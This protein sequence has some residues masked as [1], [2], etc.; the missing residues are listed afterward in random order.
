MI[1]KQIVTGFLKILIVGGLCFAVLQS[2]AQQQ[3]SLAG[4]WTVKLDSQ[5]VGLQQK[6]YSQ[7]FEETIQLP[8]T[9][10]D[11]GMGKQTNLTADKLTR[12]VVLE[13]TRKHSYIG[14]AWYSKEVQIPQNWKDK[15]ITLF[16]GRVIWN[17]RIWIDG[18]EAGSDESLSVPQRFNL[19]TLL[20]PGKHRVTIRI[21]NTKQYDI[22]HR[23]MAHAYT[24]GTQIIWNG[25]IGKISLIARNKVQINTIQT[26]PDVKNASVTVSTSFENYLNHSVSKVFRLRIFEKNK[27]LVYDKKVALNISPGENKK[28]LKISLGKKALLWDEFNPDLYKVSAEIRD[29]YGI[30]DAQTTTFGMREI[31]HEQNVLRVN[32]RQ[33]YLRGTLECDIFPLTGHPPMDKNGWLK[34]FNT[35]KEYGL[36]HIRF[37]SWCPPEPAFEVADS[38][39]FYLQ[40]ELPLWSKESGNEAK[41]NKFIADEA[42]RI[43]KEYGNHPSFCLWSLGNELEGDF[44]WLTKLLLELKAR[45]TR[46]LYTTTT[47]SFQKDHGVWPEPNDEFFITQYTKKGWVRGQGI[48]NTYSPN[49]S[50][51]Y[52]KALA[53]MPVPMITHEM[54]QYSVYPNLD[55][56]KKYTGVLDPL[57]FKAIRNDLQKKNMLELA[58]DFTLASGKFSANLYKEEIE[59]NLKTKGMSGFQL[60]DLHDFPG[61]GTA[62]V[63]ILDA[64][65]DSKGLIAPREHRMYCAPVVPLIRFS[66]AVYTNTEQFEAEAEIANFSNRELKNISTAWIVKNEQGKT[67]FN[68]VLNNTDVAVGN[69][70]SLGKFGFSLKN[71]VKAEELTI[72]MELKGTTYKNTWNI[73]VYPEKIA[74]NYKEVTFTT[75]LKEALSY[76]NEGKTVL[77]NPD[78][79]NIIGVKGRFA[80]VFW[81]PVHFPNQPG[82]MGILCDPKHP[83]LSNFPTEFYSNWQWWDLITSSKTM[84]IDSLPAM[85]PIVRVIDNFYQNRKM[86]N[87]LE[88]RVG[89]GKL[90][91]T[92]MDIS[93]NLGKR[94]VARQLRYSLE[95]YMSNKDFAPAV[96][97]NA[98][99]LAYLVNEKSN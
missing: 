39:G 99:Q 87:V 37:H 91:L 59:R 82:T 30:Q 18:R 5:N 41:T 26:Y 3:I 79:I 27:K 58:P 80:P 71:I 70:I 14:S 94:P 88:A 67:L 90:I 49:F 60:L 6:W 84:I 53:G 21:D 44:N 78:T 56:I 33:I 40:V 32:G 47:M 51:D 36:N 64:F 25:V 75:S 98:R 65:W 31:T 7:K 96:E 1:I 73:W 62:L 9:L 15:N 10:D 48:F 74:D 55:E 11:A 83:A 4:K 76:L 77:L 52:T 50:T 8:G 72:Q 81:S 12:E 38:L 43:S 95:Q 42:F 92:S 86:A 68:G 89:K 16:L 69:G 85:R 23:D 13:L 2:K 20:Q 97:L 54:G 35:A 29:E 24:D 45:D 57:N 63:G 17:T 93:H 61:Q 19:S 66:K 22:S 34:V 46:H 28:D